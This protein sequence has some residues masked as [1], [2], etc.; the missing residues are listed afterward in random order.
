MTDCCVCPNSLQDFLWSVSAALLWRLEIDSNSLVKFC[1]NSQ[2]GYFA[3]SNQTSFPFRLSSQSS[4]LQKNK[5]WVLPLQRFLS[6]VVS[7]TRGQDPPKQCSVV[8]CNRC[9]TAWCECMT[10]AA[11]QLLMKKIEV[12]KNI[13]DKSEGRG[14]MNWGA[15]IRIMQCRVSERVLR[16][17]WR[18]QHSGAGESYW[19]PRRCNH[20]HLVPT[21]SATLAVFQKPLCHISRHQLSVLRRC[22]GLNQDWFHVNSLQC[23]GLHIV[24]LLPNN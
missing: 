18:G 15:A 22:K 3:L 2:P 13:W 9:R 7:C 4:S 1:C 14:P 5:S 8:A 17:Q 6:G 19:W 23:D 24:V 10:T 12:W 11:K 16:C 20:G 21:L